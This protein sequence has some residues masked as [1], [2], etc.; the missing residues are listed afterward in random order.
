M[1]HF[2]KLGSGNIV[3][4]VVVVHNNEAS[5][6]EA[7]QAFLN[8]VYGTNDVW[9]Q[10]SYNTRG[11]KYYNSDNTLGDQSKAFRKNYAG[12]GY[13][14]DENRDAFIAPTPF[15][16]WVLNEDTCR[17]ESPIPYPTDGKMYSWNESTLTW[18][19]VEV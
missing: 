6:E 11:G 18:D 8:S 5:T 2:A 4:N 10:T 17:W 15:N 16:S 9:K 14:Y 13:I 7:G 19:I 3:E 1:A 12:K